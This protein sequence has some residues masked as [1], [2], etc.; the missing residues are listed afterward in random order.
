MSLTRIFRVLV[1]LVTLVPITA[2]IERYD[3]AA[4]DTIIKDVAIVGGGASGTY[5]AVRLREDYNTSVVVVEAQNRL[6]GHVNTYLD[7]ISG[8][9]IDYG[10]LAYS[11]IGNA[12]DFFARFNIPTTTFD[13]AAQRDVYIDITNGAVLSDFVP[14]TGPDVGAALETWQNI[15]AQYVPYVLP[16]LWNF[17]PPG[18]VPEQLLM[19][20]GELAQMYNLSAAVPTISYVSGI[21]LGGISNILTFYVMQAFGNPIVSELLA[22]QFFMPAKASNS[23]LYQ[24]AQ[25]LLGHD[26]LLQ[27]RVIYGNRSTNGVTL[28]VSNAD[29]TT[30]LIQAKKLLLTFPPSLANL[31]PF[32]PTANESALFSTWTDVYSFA[33]VIRLPGV[34]ENTTLSYLDPSSA[35]TNYLNTRNYPSTLLLTSSSTNGEHLF[36]VLYATNYSTTHR[37]AKDAITACVI[38]LQT[39]GTYLNA[40]GSADGTLE[41]LA[42]ADHNSVTWRQSASMLQ[43]G[44]VQDIYG[45]QGRE[46][47][48]YTGSLWTED[49]SGTVWDFTDSFLPRLLESLNG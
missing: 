2:A 48:W 37:Q 5:A 26:V 27:S 38:D 11:P 17:F 45:L 22:G 29:G 47:T 34:P 49:Y 40:S 19:P 21:G 3:F 41:F 32:Q 35:P 30:K 12:T 23:L 4:E 44:L 8:A 14:P 39:S 16:G 24:R 7:P 9:A 31:Q 15:T 6:G 33:G 43:D 46:S 18:Q 13:Q 28:I 20:F 1:L 36:S 25:A 10:V 42:F